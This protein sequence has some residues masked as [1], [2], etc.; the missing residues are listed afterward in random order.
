LADQL[1]EE[2]KVFLGQFTRSTYRVEIKN[3]RKESQKIIK[4]RNEEIAQAYER[5]GKKKAAE[6]YRH[7]NK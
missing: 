6:Y 7:K 5:M 1:R 4:A 2:S 3:M